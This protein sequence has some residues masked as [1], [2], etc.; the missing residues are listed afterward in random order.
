MTR[1][2]VLNLIETLA[3]NSL[4]VAVHAGGGLEHAVN[5][6]FAPRREPSR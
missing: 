4:E 1:F 3:G 5:L 6:F 2:E